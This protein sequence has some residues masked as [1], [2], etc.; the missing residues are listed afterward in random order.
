M[1]Y[2]RIYVFIETS[3]AKSL[4]A[5]LVQSGLARAYGVYRQ[6]PKDLDQDEARERMKDIELR[7]V[8]S[9][10]CNRAFRD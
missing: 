8:G 6:S 10:R 9:R 2:K 7:A 1:N 5:E 4:A 3:E